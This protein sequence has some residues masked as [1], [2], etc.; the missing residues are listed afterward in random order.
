MNAKGKFSLLY[1]EVPQDQKKVIKIPNF[2]KVLREVTDED[3]FTQR[4]ISK[5]AWYVPNKDLEYFK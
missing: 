5:K 1:I 4:V 2:V 3:D